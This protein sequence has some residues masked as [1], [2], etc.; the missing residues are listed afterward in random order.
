[1]I[2]RLNHI[3]IAVKNL[4]AARRCIATRSARRFRRRCRSPSMA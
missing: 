4:D 3:A 1:M 2:G